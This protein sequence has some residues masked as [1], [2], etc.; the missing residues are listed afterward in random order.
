MGAVV[1]VPGVF[2]G[3]LGIEVSRSPGTD[4]IASEPDQWRQSEVGI[5]L[6]L[7]LSPLQQ[8]LGVTTAATGG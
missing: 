1:E 5:A 2:R 8:F 4:W 3:G 6:T 7:S